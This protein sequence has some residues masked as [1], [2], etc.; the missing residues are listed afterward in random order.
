MS[1]KINLYNSRVA[2]KVIDGKQCTI[3]W[4]VDDNK[5]FH[6]NPKVVD[7]MIKQIEDKFGKITI[8]RGKYHVFVGMDIKFLENGK[9]RIF[10]KDCIT[11]SM[12]M[13][14]MFGEKIT[15]SANTPTKKNSCN[16]DE[17]EYSKLL[18]DTKVEVFHHMVSKLL[19]ISKRERV[20]IKLGISC[21]CTRVS[22]I[23]HGGW[24]KLKILL[25]YLKIT[26]DTPRIIGANRLEV[27]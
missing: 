22:C 12:E 9:V 6:M 17:E 14:D 20:D 26:I 19:Y 25:T 7:H 11:E 18:G 5:I 13:F 8:T 21:L 24:E 16:K 2:N 3:L 23:T 10:I 27:L 4:Y 15:K 1:F